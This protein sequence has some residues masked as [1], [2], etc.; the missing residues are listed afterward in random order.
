MPFLKSTWT[1]TELEESILKLCEEFP[2]ARMADCSRAL[3][4]C[5][6]AIPH[7]TPESL[8]IA[9]REKLR[10]PPVSAATVRPKHRLN[11]KRSLLADS[12]RNPPP[13]DILHR[14]KSN[15]FARRWSSAHGERSPHVKT[16]TFYMARPFRCR[17]ISTVERAY[18]RD[19]LERIA[20]IGGVNTDHTRWNLSQPAAIALIEKGTDEFFFRVGEQNVRVVVLTCDG[21][22]Y[23]Q[24]EREKTHPDDLLNFSAACVA[25]LSRP[26]PRLAGVLRRRQPVTVASA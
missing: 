5:R 20:S 8:L 11:E 26:V 15:Y 16:Q 23:L 4:Y 9:M 3:E 12:R 7:G 25:S 10:R 14:K 21:E 1:D 22:K 18:S 17:A 24:S 2:D 13:W 19:P 6:R